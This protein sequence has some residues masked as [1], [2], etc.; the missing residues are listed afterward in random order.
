MSLCRTASSTCP[1]AFRDAFKFWHSIPAFFSFSLTSLKL[2]FSVL[3]SDWRAEICN[4]MI[5]RNED[6]RL[7]FLAP[8]KEARAGVIAVGTQDRALHSRKYWV[9]LLG[10]QEQS[11]SCWENIYVLFSQPGESPIS[12]QPGGGDKNFSQEGRFCLAK[13]KG[14]TMVGRAKKIFQELQREVLN[15]LL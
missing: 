3:E 15:K 6:Q 7:T 9:L 4:Q 2:S 1:L 14:N 11:T 12:F 5:D 10:K 8:W 13:K